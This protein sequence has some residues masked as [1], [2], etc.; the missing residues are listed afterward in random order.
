MFTGE[1]AGIW[2]AQLTITSHQ[3][4]WL[5]KDAEVV[6]DSGW[7]EKLKA[8]VTR[9][10]TGGRGAKHPDAKIEVERYVSVKA[11]DEVNLPIGQ[12]KAI[13]IDFDLRARAFVGEEKVE[14]VTIDD[15]NPGSVW[16]VPDVGVVKYQDNFKTKKVWELVSTTVPL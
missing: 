13:K 11:K 14:L 4:V 6:A 3:D 7:Q 12:W 16:L 8:D 5:H 10:D 9:S 2:G 1:P 15:K